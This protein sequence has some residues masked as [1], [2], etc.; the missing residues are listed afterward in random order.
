LEVRPTEVRGCYLAA[1]GPRSFTVNC[2]EKSFQGQV[3]IPPGLDDGMK[4]GLCFG[5]ACF[6]RRTWSG[7]GPCGRG[8]VRAPNVRILPRMLSAWKQSQVGADFLMAFS[9]FLSTKMKVYRGAFRSY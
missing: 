4:G 3:Q 8:P 7:P 1:P 2:R 9:V 6:A 5:R